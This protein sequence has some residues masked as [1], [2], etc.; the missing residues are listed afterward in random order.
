MILLRTQIYTCAIPR[1]TETSPVSFQYM[2]AN[3]DLVPAPSACMMLQYSAAAGMRV[4]HQAL[5][6]ILLSTDIHTYAHLVA[7]MRNMD[8]CMGYTKTRPRCQNSARKARFAVCAQ[9]VGHS[10]KR[11]RPGSPARRSGMILQNALGYKPLSICAGMS[12]SQPAA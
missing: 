5:A 10:R 11:H 8:T 7:Y 3:D 2:Y 12:Q 6:R 1:H 9:R 4:S